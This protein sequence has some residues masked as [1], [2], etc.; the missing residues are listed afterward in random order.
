[1]ETERRD[2]APGPAGAPAG[3]ATPEHPEPR[4]ADAPSSEAPSSAA[5]RGEGPKGEPPKGEAPQISLAALL[6]SVPAPELLTTF[7]Q[8]LAAKAWEGMGLVPSA[9]TNKV[10]KNLDEARVAIDAYAA[11]LE[12]LR[13]RLEPHPRQEMENVLTMLRV[14]FVDKSRT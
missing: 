2:E 12:V 11:V 3:E 10:Q 4:P 7:C 6:A 13:A 5:P 8:V 1:M 14:N 9:V